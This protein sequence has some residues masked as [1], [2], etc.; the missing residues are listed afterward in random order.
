MAMTGLVDCH[1]HL[2]DPDLAGRLDE[3]LGRARAAGVERLVV[4]GSSEDDWPAVLDLARRLPEVVPCFGL[5]PWYVGERSSRWIEALEGH[6]AAVPSAVGEI[7]LDQWKKGLD[8]GAQEECFRAQVDLARRL[9]RPAMVHCVQ[10]WGWL[11]DVLGRDPLPAGLLVHAFGGSVEAMGRLADL[12]AFFSFAGDTLEERKTHKREAAR[13]A[14]LDRIL[15][16]T[17]AP[18]MLP[19]PAFR[20]ASVRDDRGRERNEPANLPDVLRGIAALR[21][22]PE[23]RLAAAVG[24]N[25][26]RLL[27]SLLVERGTP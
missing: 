25:A 6:L 11:L 13:A 24:E 8:E 27:G 18:D 2:Q 16:E 19:P 5:H 4:N 26:R 23:E 21:G 15:V 17:D 7:G 3:V 12:G 1:L 14:P 9:R 10:A 20:R 22:E